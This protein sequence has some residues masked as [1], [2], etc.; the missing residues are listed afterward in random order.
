MENE[1]MVEVKNL[2]KLFSAHR[3]LLGSMFSRKKETF[4]Y[5]VDGLS[6]RIM[7]GEMFGLVG[8][9][10][11]GK[12]TTGKLLL[13]LY[14]PTSGQIF[15]KGKEMTKLKGR[16]LRN[17]RK[18]AQMIFQ[19]PY[20]SLDPRYTVHDTICEPLSIHHIKLS[21]DQK[22]EAVC[23]MLE[24]VELSPAQYFVERFPSELSG[25]QRQRVAIARA[26]MTDPEF[27]VAD[28]PVSMLDA[29]VRA[30]IIKLL[31]KLRRDFNVTCL[32][33]THDLSVARYLCDRIAVMYIGRIVE[34]GHK[35]DVI[36]NA[37]Q[38]YTKVLLTSVPVIDTKYRRQRKVSSHIVEPSAIYTSNGCR[39]YPRCPE[40]K[41]ICKRSEP[42]L[43]EVEHNHYVACHLI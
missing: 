38:P 33:I 25:G 37:L 30:G 8:E 28:E 32:F 27:I 3:G 42:I 24:K 16:D 31:L 36:S 19:D 23:G 6:F 41:D 35:E 18:T 39:F 11:S 29:S 34:I 7:N 26:L 9:S 10:G 20:E 17:W 15:F 43:R 14:E 2:K 13:R 21:R 4:I 40:R 12:T 1:P 22:T 5:A